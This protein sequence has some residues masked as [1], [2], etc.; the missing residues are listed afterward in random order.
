ML[1]KVCIM[2][3]ACLLILGA[4]S[5]AEWAQERPP[6]EF[7]RIFMTRLRSGLLC[8]PPLAGPHEGWC[9]AGG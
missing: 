1:K 3:V 2:A 8:E 5:V 6:E 9:G 7:Q 4:A